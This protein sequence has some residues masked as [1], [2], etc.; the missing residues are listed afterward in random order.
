MG[1]FK[2]SKPPV[3]FETDYSKYLS[4]YNNTNSRCHRVL[5]KHL[6]IEPECCKHT[7]LLG[8]AEYILPTIKANLCQAQGS[9]VI[10]DKSAELYEHTHEVLE[11]RGYRVH[12]MTALKY[13]SPTAPKEYNPFTYI[14]TAHDVEALVDVL[15]EAMI[16]FITDEKYIPLI[17]QTKVCLQLAIECVRQLSADQQHMQMVFTVMQDVDVHG[18]HNSQY[19]EIFKQSNPIL[20]QQMLDDPVSAQREWFILLYLGLQSIM[21]IGFRGTENL[22]TWD[23]LNDGKTAIFIQLPEEFDGDNASTHQMDVLLWQL[24]QHHMNTP[25]LCWIP[26]C[27]LPSTQILNNCIQNNIH[28]FTCVQEL[29]CKSHD[30][31][32]AWTDTKCLYD[33]IVF[34]GSRN[35]E[36]LDLVAQNP[37]LQERYD[38]YLSYLMRLRRNPHIIYE[39]EILHDYLTLIYPR[40]CL[41]IIGKFPPFIDESLYIDLSAGD[42]DRMSEN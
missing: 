4:R 32:Q 5:S 16:P 33:T 15:I 36:L 25:V 35:W 8:N 38:K 37:I 21:P 41:V 23:E 2:K 3:V 12:L 31:K 11:S 18:W 13:W 1:L 10:F 7:L 28:C 9:Y 34:F 24:S 22:F 19:A 14:H 6:A 39:Y 40:Y 29:L 20:Y 26:D 30:Y 27:S 17:P 42:C